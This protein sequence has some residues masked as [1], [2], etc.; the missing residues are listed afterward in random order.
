MVPNK[1]RSAVFTWLCFLTA[2]SLIA[3]IPYLLS[4]QRLFYAQKE[5]YCVS[6][7]SLRTLS[8][9]N[10]SYGKGHFGA[11]RNGGRTHE[12]VDFTAPLGTSVLAVKSGR[13]LVSA[14]GKSYGK[15]IQ[16][17]HS[18]GLMSCYAHLSSLGVKKGD[19]VR[20]MAILGKSGKSGNADRPRIKPHLH[21]EIRNHQKPLNPLKNN[22]LDKTLSIN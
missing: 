4:K 2:F 10:D 7:L 8:V 1:L 22:I 16:L 3:G 13:V 6:P 5:P 20:Q 14:T 9:R 11:P 17:I 12:G 21:F 15:Y 18:D 19:W